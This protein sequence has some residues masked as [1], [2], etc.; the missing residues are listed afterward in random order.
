MFEWL[1]HLLNVFSG[2]LSML[3]I[4][5]VSLVA[6]SIPLVGIP[7]LAVV[8]AYSLFIQDLNIKLLLILSSALGATV[9][10]LIIYIIGSSFRLVLSKKVIENLRLFSR[11]ADK[12]VFLAIFLFAS[13][14]LPDDVLYIPTGMS[15]YSLP[16]Y[17]VAVLLGKTALTSVV[18]LYSHLI[19][20]YASLNSFLLPVYVVMTVIFSYIIIKIDWASVLNILTYEGVLGSIKEFLRQLTVIFKPKIKW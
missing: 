9:G 14:P 2:P 20:E 7:Y 6:N 15:R 1:W 12:S 4:F 13:L 3:G 8:L 10:K 17:V 16:K 18:V 11:V 5:A 19:S